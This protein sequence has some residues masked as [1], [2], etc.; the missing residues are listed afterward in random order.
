MSALGGKQTL[1]L[2]LARI[3]ALPNLNSAFIEIIEQARVDAHFTE[4][5]PKSLP[6]GSAAAD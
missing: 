6:V 4:V 2:G 1:V 3:V 5:F